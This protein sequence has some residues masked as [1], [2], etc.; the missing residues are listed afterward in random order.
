M[1]AKVYLVG[2]G[3]GDPGLI[4]VKGRD[5]IAAADVVIYDYLASPAL[6]ACARADAEL[7]YVGKKGGDHTLSQE[8]INR[9]LV[10]KALPGVTVTRLK[11]GDPF[12]FGRGGEEAEILAAEN[13]SYEIVP[14][15]TSA[16][17]AA[18]YAGIP[19]T[20][21]K[22]TA[23]VAFVTG[24]EDPLKAESNVDWQAL[25]TGIGTLVF[26]MGVKNLADIAQRLVAA[27]RPA[28]TPVAV[29]RWGTTAHQQTVVG[30]LASIDARAREAGIKAPAII[31][32][33]A[34]VAL[35]DTLRWYEERPLLGKTIVVTRAR[36]QASDLVERLSDLGAACLEIPTIRVAPPEDTRPL[37]R[38]IGRL[39]G[40][41]WIVFTSVNGVSFF[42]ERLFAAGLDVRALHR[43][44]TAAIGPATAARLRTFG[45]NTDIIPSTYQAE[46][47][48]AAFA[49]EALGGKKI[50]VARAQ[51]ARP[52][53]PIE[54]RK[55]GAQVDEVPAYQTLAVKD[56]LPELIGALS[57]GKVD[58]VTFTSSSTVKNFVALL[59]EKDAAR[60][61]SGVTVAC[62]GPITADTA[63]AL[64]L[65]V[66]IVAAAFTIPGL[67][68]AIVD[69]FT[70]LAPSGR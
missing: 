67:C 34:V 53:L 11:G 1:K 61:L 4:T 30:T 16:I 57:A 43:L 63:K 12:I 62:I 52:I 25:A 26:F 2:A 45:L 31:V 65:Q 41:D 18:A 40:Y 35:R 28:Q 5:C 47:V 27:G 70:V 69:Y 64:G 33:G 46:A 9:L 29:I 48:I 51:E 58:A 23:T 10:A 21:R 66:D 17:A 50:L 60:L 19:L 49:G 36:E 56:G 20:H 24:H 14:G 13:I 15:V 37:S 42:F 44:R 68:D 54:L 55:M 38:A 39:E 22:M 59:P 7:I 6:L 32:V 8:E 3:P